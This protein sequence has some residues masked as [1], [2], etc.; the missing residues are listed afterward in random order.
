MRRTRSVVTEPLLTTRHHLLIHFALLL[1]AHSL[2][3]TTRSG[4]RLDKL[5][6]PSVHLVDQHVDV[7]WFKPVDEPPGNTQRGEEDRRERV[8][9]RVRVFVCVCVCEVR[10]VRD[11]SVARISNRKARCC[12]N[13]VLLVRRAVAHVVR[14]PEAGDVARGAAADNAAQVARVLTHAAL[15]QIVVANQRLIV[16]AVLI[17]DL[18]VLEVTKPCLLLLHDIAQFLD[19]HIAVRGPRERVRVA[20]HVADELLVVEDTRPAAALPVTSQARASVRDPVHRSEVNRLADSEAVRE[21]GV[22]R[23][24]ERDNK[25]PRAL[26]KLHNGDAL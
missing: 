2:R 15:T 11:G 12:C 8:R 1:V 13:G 17:R 7:L 5:V 6:L 26:A 23:A 24:W 19:E 18:Q 16:Q 21:S 9:V 10:E 25:L 20:C 3:S 22:V 4:A 14:A